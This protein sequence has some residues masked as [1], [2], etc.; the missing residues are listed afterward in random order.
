MSSAAEAQLL[1][2][3][4]SLWTN[5]LSMLSMLKRTCIGRDLATACPPRAIAQLRGDD[6]PPL[7]T[8]LHWRDV[9][10]ADDAQ[11]PALDD[12]PHPDGECQRAPALVA[13]IKDLAIAAQPACVVTPA[14]GMLLRDL[15]TW[16]C[17]ML[18]C[19]PGWRRVH[20]EKPCLIMVPLLA[21]L[22]VPTLV[23]SYLRPLELVCSSAA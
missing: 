15:A 12:L 17:C 7:A 20:T 9:I 4:V 18:R 5:M 8:L 19:M 16:A 23:S 22:P 14:T 11:I 6:K 3:P 2:A 13:R 10:S 21:S 1:M